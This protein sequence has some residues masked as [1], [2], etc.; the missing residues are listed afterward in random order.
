MNWAQIPSFQIVHLARLV[1]GTPLLA[2]KSRIAINTVTPI[3]FNVPLV[4]L[5]I[6]RPK[7][8]I[9]APKIS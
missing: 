9:P 6:P 5:T 3:V 2:E 7:S 4:T 1:T 8:V